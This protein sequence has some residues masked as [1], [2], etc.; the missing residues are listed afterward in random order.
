MIEN[1]SLY[2]FLITWHVIPEETRSSP[3]ENCHVMFCSAI[4]FSILGLTQFDVLSTSKPDFAAK[5]KASTA[6][7]TEDHTC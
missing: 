1:S 5:E 7:F 4:T 3:Q 6:I 2:G